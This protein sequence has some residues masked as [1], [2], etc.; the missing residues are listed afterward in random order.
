MTDDAII[1]AILKIANDKN[2]IKLVESHVAFPLVLD[3]WA[4]ER[5]L[6]AIELL[7]EEWKNVKTRK[8]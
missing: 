8:R 3:R 4:V 1:E 2:F 7:Q 6:G 5:T